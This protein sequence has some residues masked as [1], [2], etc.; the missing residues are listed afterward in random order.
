[1]WVLENQTPFAAERTW[2]RDVNGAE[3][4]ITAIKGTF[5]LTS[6]GQLSLADTQLPVTL[7]PSYQDPQSSELLYDTDVPERK[8]ATD[9][10]VNGTAY[11]PDGRAMPQWKAN[12]RVGPINKTLLITGPRFWQKGLLSPTLSEPEPLQSLPLSYRHA[13]GGTHNKMAYPQNPI[14]CGYYQN[15]STLFDRAIPNIEYASTPIRTPNDL[16]IPAGFTALPSHWQPRLA[17]AGTY[18]SKWENHRFPL[19]PEDFNP[20]FYQ[21]APLDQQVPGF[22]K[23]GELVE[24]TH[25]SPVNRLQF[26]LPIVS[27]L[28][29]TYFTGGHVEIHRANLHTVII[30][31]DNHRVILV[32][33]SH[34]PCHHD[35]NRLEKTTIQL[36]KRV[37]DKNHEFDFK[38]KSPGAQN[39]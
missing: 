27:F 29:R 11:A 19:L 17:F 3:V 4:W 10:I 26:Y 9:V 15:A 14:G 8:T 25:L 30:E 32:W 1:M 18:D 5:E 21:S 31:P 38:I 23:G 12:L 39:V 7:A 2:V 22:L 20:L 28:L 34:L 24:I 37:F 6:Y 35:I 33:H 16:T 36:K 13:F